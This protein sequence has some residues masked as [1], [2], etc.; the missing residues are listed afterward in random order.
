MAGYAY[1]AIDPNGKEKK[2][3]MEAPDQDRVFHSLKAEGYFPVSIKEIGILNRDIKINI[4][5]PVKPRDLSVFTRQFVSILKAGVPIVSALEMLVEQTENK[6]LKKA[7]QNTQLMVEKGERLADAMRNQGKIFP[8]V[9]I[10]MVEAGET[11]GSLEVALDR[12]ST[13]FEKEAKLKALIKKSMVY[14]MMLGIVSLS[15]VILML[16]F[17]IPSFMSMFKD[18]N[19]KMPPVTLAIVSVSNFVVT[20]WYI[21]V[22]A[23][24]AI[25]LGITG[26]KSTY[27]GEILFAKLGLHMPLFGKLQVKS[28]SA[29]L[30]RTLS[31]LLAAGIP[32]I[33]AID[34]TARTM[35]NVVIKKLLMQSQ[36]EVARGVPLSV[37]LKA[38]G[39]FPP[40]V[41]HMIKIGEDTGNLEAMLVT[42][43]D[44]YDE[45][46]EVATQSLMAMMEPL[47]IIVLAIV[48]GG[49][50]LAIIQPMFSMY[51]QLD[52]SML[53]GD[54]GTGINP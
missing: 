5:T 47:I 13:H 28:A 2:G 52:A 31:T 14:P 6:N 24:L 42:I 46:V 33:D 34:I 49:L 21:I 44:Y 54:P 29:R 9:L 18:M 32:L 37:P 26:F 15:V 45:E 1:V 25:V 41:Y 51:D 39:I 17:V 38:S 48:V 11:S 16:A 20:K 19:L 35:D 3:K 23:I 10:N 12:M 27:K 8:P 50:V 43:A 40:M 7:I 4:T 53:G 22:G 30:T 36:E